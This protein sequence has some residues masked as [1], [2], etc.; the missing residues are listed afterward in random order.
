MIDEITQ[1][2][3]DLYTIGWTAALLCML[4]S[5]W[6]AQTYLLRHQRLST[7]MALLACAWAL[8]LGAYADPHRSELSSLARNIAAILFVYIGGL[9]A[10]EGHH[11]PKVPIHEKYA[12]SLLFFVVVP[13]AITFPDPADTIIRAAKTIPVSN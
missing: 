5:V 10:A 2:T 13:S 8:V 3:R 11:S 12:M 1:T 7:A 9:L 6:I 4:I